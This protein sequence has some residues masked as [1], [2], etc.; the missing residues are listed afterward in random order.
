VSYGLAITDYVNPFQQIDANTGARALVVHSSV[1]KTYGLN[2]THSF[3]KELDVSLGISLARNDSNFALDQQEDLD[4]LLSNLV[5]ALGSYRKLTASLT[6][7]K[8]F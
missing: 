4:E 1:G 2:V 3:R 8:T 6:V 5:S 7:S